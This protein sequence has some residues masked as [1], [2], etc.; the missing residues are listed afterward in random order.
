[1]KPSRTRVGAAGVYL[2]IILGSVIVAL[3]TASVAFAVCGDGIVDPGE[4][5]DGNCPT[6]LDVRVDASSDDAEERSRRRRVQSRSSDH[7]LV[8]DRRRRQT[9]GVR[10]NALPMT[11]DRVLARIE[12]L[13]REKR[14]KR[15]EAVGGAR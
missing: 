3:G 1:M 2:A 8:D 13:E 6:S 10:F 15:G 7:E 4:T 14:K 5:C 11:P 9:V 12:A